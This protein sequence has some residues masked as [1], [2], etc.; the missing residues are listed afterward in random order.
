MTRRRTTTKKAE[1]EPQPEQ[2][3][4]FTI[5]DDVKELMADIFDSPVFPKINSMDDWMVQSIRQVAK[6]SKQ[7]RMWFDHRMLDLANN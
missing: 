4:R 1:P 2:D 3:E 6:D 5:P 7:F